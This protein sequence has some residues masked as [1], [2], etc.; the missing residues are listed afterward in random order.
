MQPF[1]YLFA[2]FGFTLSATAGPSKSDALDTLVR[3]AWQHSPELR[4]AHARWSASRERPAQVTPLP[5]PAVSYT[6][7]VQRMDTRQRFAIEQ[8]LPDPARRRLALESARLDADLAAAALLETALNVRAAVWSAAADWVL[9]HGTAKNLRASLALARTQ[10][11]IALQHYRAGRLPQTELLRLG[12]DIATVEAELAAWADRTAP[13]LARLHALRGRPADDSVDETLAALDT[14]P[15]LPPAPL[16]PTIDLAAQPALA[17]AATRVRQS[18]IAASIA[19]LADRPEWTLGLEFMDN[20]GM[21]RD[22]LA[23]MV[24]VDLPVWRSRVHSLRREALAALRAAEADRTARRLDLEI[25]AAA[26]WQEL[27]DAAR[28]HAL[29]TDT[30]VPLARQ[31][32]ALLSA[33]YRS[34]DGSLTALLEAQQA[35]LALEQAALVAHAEHLRRRATWERLAAPFVSTSEL[36]ADHDTSRP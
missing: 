10:E 1:T 17:A 5:D 14:L 21:A 28:R 2:L 34:T 19:R 35:L 9:V 22:E 24:T 15:V 16:A 4:A 6:A 7:F 29:Y 36:A 12:N 11:R 26:A 32:V 31:S 20:R 33:A 13:I 8:M 18:D 27:R 30:L 23:A 3:E 25:D